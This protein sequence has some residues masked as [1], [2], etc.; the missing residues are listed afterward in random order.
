[1]TEPALSPFTDG[2]TA[3]V[4]TAAV[5]S[6]PGSKGS[7]GARVAGHS[8]LITDHILPIRIPQ[9][10][11]PKSLTFSL[12]TTSFTLPL[13]NTLFQTG[14]PQAFVYLPATT[15]PKLVEAAVDVTDP[16]VEEF[17]N[18]Q[19]DIQEAWQ[20]LGD[21]MKMVGVK[22]GLFP[23]TPVPVDSVEIQINE[24]VLKDGSGSGKIFSSLPLKPL[25]PSRQITEGMGNILRELDTPAGVQPGASRE[26]EAAVD[27]YIESLP[28]SQAVPERV[29]VFARLTPCEPSSTPAELLLYPGA[30]IHRVLSGGG[31]WG[32]KAGL[33]SLDPQGDRDISNFSN[34][35]EK[36]FDG[37]DAEHGGIVKK[38]EWVQFFVTQ[39]A[40]PVLKGLQ[41]G[42]VGK[43]EAVDSAL[44]GEEKMVD[45]VF[46][47]ASEMGVDVG[48]AGRAR[49]MD[50]PGG[51]VVVDA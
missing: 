23:H 37:S 30:R 43:V 18:A 46:G 29:D 32:S 34:E 50:V 42:A 13:A 12:P 31:G 27:K 6:L 17:A 9:N 8:W 2:S 44:A 48:V 40:E 7:N 38:G 28:A 39:D 4:L 45:G 26:L 22:S 35:F 20:E 36:R 33:L 21:L 3:T 49:R 10:G 19:E 25:T 24:D 5:D 14:Q 1:M 16:E 47:G 15:K 51:T 11:A 41:F